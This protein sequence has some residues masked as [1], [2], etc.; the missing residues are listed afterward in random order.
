MDIFFRCQSCDKT[1]QVDSEKPAQA[2]KACGTEFPLNLSDTV[3]QDNK[4]DVCPTCDKSVFY[5]QRD[6][7]QKVGA[8]IMAVFAL[9]GLFFVWLDY[10]LF[11]YLCLGAGALFDFLLYLLLPEITICYACKTAFRNV[12]PNS[13]HKPFDLHIADVYDGKA[14][15]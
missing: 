6:F 10:P 4:V 3:R 5:V 14:K 12:S 13:D 2:C 1:I 11:F 15:G 8:A 9:L 7:N